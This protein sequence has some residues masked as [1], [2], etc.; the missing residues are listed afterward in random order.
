MCY[1]G[2]SQVHAVGSSFCAKDIF[3]PEKAVAHLFP[4]KVSHCGR[5]KVERQYPSKDENQY[6]DDH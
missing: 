5:S 6:R 2:M 1:E 3:S 4:S